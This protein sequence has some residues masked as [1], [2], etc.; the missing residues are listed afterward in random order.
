MQWPSLCTIT[1]QLS[2]PRPPQISKSSA[3]DLQGSPCKGDKPVPRNRDKTGLG[4]CYYVIVQWGI[5]VTMQELP[6]TVTS[7]YILVDRRNWCSC[8]PKLTH[9]VNNLLWAARGGEGD[10]PE[11]LTC[12]PLYPNMYNNTLRSDP[13]VGGDYMAMSLPDGQST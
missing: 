7:K 8:Y 6:S 2:L 3:K 11:D 13:C 9:E 4:A 5:A 1:V 12:R 10:L